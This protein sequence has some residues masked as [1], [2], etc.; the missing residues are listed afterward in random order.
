MNQDHIEARPVGSGYD[1]L[2]GGERLYNET[3]SSEETH[4]SV[5][6]P[7]VVVHKIRQAQSSVPLPTMPAPKVPNSSIEQH[8]KAVSK[9]HRTGR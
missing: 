7:E 5:G 6:P 8:Q 2:A 9:T 3:N 4:Y 1:P